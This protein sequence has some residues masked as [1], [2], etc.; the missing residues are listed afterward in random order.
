MVVNRDTSQ[1][2]IFPKG[3]RDGVSD[4]WAWNHDFCHVKIVIVRH[5]AF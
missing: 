5:C 2:A 4:D 1:S 3:H